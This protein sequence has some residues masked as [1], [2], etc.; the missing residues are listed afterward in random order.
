LNTDPVTALFRHSPLEIPPQIHACFF[1]SGDYSRGAHKSIYG[2]SP[3]FGIPRET[4]SYDL[5][6]C[7]RS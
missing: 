6:A 4:K 3:A 7:P 5:I 2:F 1:V